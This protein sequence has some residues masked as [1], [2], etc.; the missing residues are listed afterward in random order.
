L[1][2]AVTASVL[3]SKEEKA[4]SSHDNPAGGHLILGHT[5]ML[6]TFTLTPD[7][8]YIITADRDEHIRVSWYPQGFNIERF[9]L[10]HQK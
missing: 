8:R 10:G 2:P 3:I 7:E 4:L 6:T 9:C 5:S 1:R